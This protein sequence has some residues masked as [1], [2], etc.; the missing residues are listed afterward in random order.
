[1]SAEKRTGGIPVSGLATQLQEERRPRC[2]QFR[3][4]NMEELLYPIRGHCVRSCR[5]GWLMIPS[6]EEYGT[7]CTRLGFA[8]C[9][10]FSGG[11]DPTRTVADA[12]DEPGSYREPRW[13]AEIDEPHLSGSV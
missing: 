11:E 5:P 7:Y 9:C 13:P 1:M 3:A 2:P 6:I 8:Q 10:W 12:W 4:C